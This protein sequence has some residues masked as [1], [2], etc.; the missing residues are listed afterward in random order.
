MGS[1]FQILVLING[2]QTVITEY[3]AVQLTIC[4]CR[5]PMFMT[6]MGTSTWILLQDYGAQR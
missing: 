4:I 2:I 6:L 1:T 5:V 3:F